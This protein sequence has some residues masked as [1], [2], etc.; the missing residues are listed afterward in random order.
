MSIGTAVIFPLAVEHFY[1]MASDRLT[2]DDELYQHILDMLQ[3]VMCPHHNNN[4][5]K[6]IVADLAWPVCM[7]WRKE[8]PSKEQQLLQMIADQKEHLHRQELQLHQ[9]QDRLRAIDDGNESLKIVVP[10]ASVQASF[11]QNK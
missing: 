7:Q 9:A 10:V 8:N 1:N 6:K 5:K 11:T 4:A 3:H 2:T